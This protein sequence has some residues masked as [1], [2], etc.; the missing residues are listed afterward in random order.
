MRN[1]IHNCANPYQGQYK[2]VLC[3]CSAGLLRS[4]TMAVVLSA[5]PY[6]FNC[7]AVGVDADHALIPIDDVLLHWADEVV[8][9]DTYQR[10]MVE[11]KLLELKI[12]TKV[13]SLNL[14]DEY[15][16]RDPQL[17]E[18]IAERYDASGTPPVDF[19]PK[20]VRKRKKL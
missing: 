6:N 14:P 13:R 17:M 11:A 3:V 8:C 2:K 20:K 12:E 19:K 9:A 10:D 16:Y 5:P 18:I 7:R 4:P 1:R 15:D